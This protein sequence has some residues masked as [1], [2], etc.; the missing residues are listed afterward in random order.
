MT[1][2][3]PS[4]SSSPCPGVGAHGTESCNPL[5]TWLI[6]YNQ[7]PLNNFRICL[8]LTRHL[9]FKSWFFCLLHVELW[10]NCVSS[11]NLS[12]LIFSM[13]C[14]AGIWPGIKVGSALAKADR[15]RQQWFECLG[16]YFLCGKHVLSF[17]LWFQSCYHCGCLVIEPMDR[18]TFFCAK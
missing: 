4:A 11:L 14:E 10:P 12:F 2:L 7:H 3:S 13:Q 6:S 16:S 18:T 15:G 1:K 5:T 17:Q 9:S 8:N